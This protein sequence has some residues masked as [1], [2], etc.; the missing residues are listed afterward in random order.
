MSLK[1]EKLIEINKILFNL[2][3]IFKFLRSNKKCFIEEG[4]V[5]KEGSSKE[6]TENSSEEKEISPQ[7]AASDYNLQY[8][9]EL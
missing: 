7:E 4:E 3:N 9:M 5:L 1:L 6:V 8:S 2:I